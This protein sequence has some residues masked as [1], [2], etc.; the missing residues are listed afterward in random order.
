MP[1]ELAWSPGIGD[2]TPVGWFI[3]AAYAGVAALCA[4]VAAELRA[5]R[6]PAGDDRWLARYWVGLTLLFAFLAFNKQLDL[7]SLFTEVARHWALTS[8]WYEDRGPVIVTFILTL[9]VGSVVLLVWLVRATRHHLRT[10]RLSLFGLGFT[11]AFI[12]LRASSAHGV[13]GF[14][15]R[16][17]LGLPWNHILELTGI[18]LVGLAALRARSVDGPAFS[19]HTA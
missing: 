12:V 16:V 2:P 10:L 11:L 3:V 4:R 17:F 7:Q 6:E 14:L 5:A 19:A 15:G 1:E 8:G 13:D 9:G 18:T